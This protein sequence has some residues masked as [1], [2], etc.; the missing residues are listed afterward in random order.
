MG[1]LMKNIS[2]IGNRCVGCRSCEQVC[3]ISCISINENHEGFLY[4][5]VDEDACILCGRCINSCPIENREIHRNQPS[6]VWAVTNTNAENIMNSASGGASDIFVRTTLRN[7]GVAF[8]AVY[9][10]K[11]HVHHIEVTTVDDAYK[12][13]SSKY[14]QSDTE[15]V[16]TQIKDRLKEGRKVLFTGTPCQVAG[17][18]SF[19]GGDDENLYTIDLICHGVPSPKLFKKYVEYMEKILGEKLIYYNFRSKEKRGW[20]THYLLKTKTKTKTNALSLDRY[21]KHFLASD[22]L[23]EC[24]YECAYASIDRVGDITVG[25]FWGISKSHP[26][27]FTAKGVSSVFVNTN[28]GYSMLKQMPGTEKLEKATLEEGMMKQGNL[29]KPS[30]RPKSR[31]HFYDHIDDPDFIENMKIGSEIKERVKSMIPTKVINKLKRM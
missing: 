22:C 10:E 17:L 2:T 27:F 19:L 21:G 14:V 20:G 30:E 7:N 26:D 15:N 31:D 28:K 3:P 6:E 1:L 13:Q 18:Y 9:D 23:R 4:P 11:F 5:S 16:Y 24:C 8:G 25:D 12:F 29:R